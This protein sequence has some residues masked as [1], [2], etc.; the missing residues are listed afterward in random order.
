ME[1][2]YISKYFEKATAAALSAA[3]VESIEKQA[4]HLIASEVE[5]FAYAL[6]S[7][8]SKMAEAGRRSECTASDIQAAVSILNPSSDDGATRQYLSSEQKRKL[9]ATVESSRLSGHRKIDFRF[10]Q[11]NQNSIDVHIKSDEVSAK[12]LGKRLQCFPEWLQKEI[13]SKQH[14]G[15]AT[16]EKLIDSR[17]TTKS[18]DTKHFNGQPKNEGPLSFISSLVLAEEESREILTKKVK[19]EGNNVPFSANSG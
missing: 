10:P 16:D 7:H 19:L 13:E 4:L 8:A 18:E 1:S 14:V 17:S 15:T 5:R 11:F 3:G 12:S 9:R 2:E 6:G